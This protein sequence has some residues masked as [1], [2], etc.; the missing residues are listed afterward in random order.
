MMLMGMTQRGTC[1]KS[2]V[3]T[4]QKNGLQ[5]LKSYF[6]ASFVQDAVIILLTKLAFMLLFVIIYV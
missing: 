1:T 6:L 3:G 4:V 2:Y 5:L